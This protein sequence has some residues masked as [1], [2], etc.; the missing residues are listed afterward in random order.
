V[1]HR[2]HLLLRA[3][4]AF[5]VLPGTVAFALPLLVFRPPV[6]RGGYVPWGLGIATV[7]VAGLLWCVVEFF[8]RGRGTLAPWSP[9]QHLVVSGPYRRSRNPMYLSVLL[10]LAGWAV[11]FR[12]GDLGVYALVMLIVF[13]VRVIAFEEPWLARTFP[14]GWRDYA[15]RVPRWLGRESIRPAR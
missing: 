15:A 8:V 7:G 9:P 5:V 11:A 10:I 6:P 13:H 4:V 2:E 1:T 12:A 14:A 3:I